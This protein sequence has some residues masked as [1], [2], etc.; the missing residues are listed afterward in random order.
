MGL[1][2]LQESL[3]TWELEGTPEDL[4]ALLAGR[5]RAP[6]RRS[7]RRPGRPLVPATRRHAGTDR[8]GLRAARS[9]AAAAPGSSW[10]A[11]SSTASPTPTA[12]RSATPVRLSGRRGRG[13]PSR[14]RRCTQRAPVPADRR[15]LRAPG[16]GRA[17]R[18]DGSRQRPR[19]GS[20]A[21]ACWPAISRRCARWSASTQDIRR[22][23]P[24]SS[25]ARGRAGT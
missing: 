14:R 11:A 4:A 2:L 25:L 1:W 24:R 23:E 7:G 21:A 18:G 15:R 6:L 5:R 19:P 10:C 9:A 22:F 12:G 20:R 16:P 13:G 8:G 17:G 3:R